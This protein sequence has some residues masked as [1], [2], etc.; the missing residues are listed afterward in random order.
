ML[1]QYCKEQY[2]HLNFVLYVVAINKSLP[3]QLQQWRVA[4]A[5]Q[6]SPV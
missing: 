1:A 4:Y 3:F 5:D 2:N 6:D